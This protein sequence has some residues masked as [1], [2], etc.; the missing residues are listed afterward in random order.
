[1]RI[2]LVE[3][4]PKL[5]DFIHRGLVAE[6]F[7]TDV[8]HDGES[9]WDFASTYE[10][11][12]IILDLMLPL[13]DGS[14]VLRRIRHKNQQVPIFVVTA[15]D[16]VNDKVHTFEAGADDYLTKPFSFAELL[17]RVKALLRTGSG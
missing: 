6:R 2:L 15:R 13:L 17:V 16:S 12:L 1:M 5:A 14:E 9:G 10:Y 7:A 3:D 8:T 4:E 11:D